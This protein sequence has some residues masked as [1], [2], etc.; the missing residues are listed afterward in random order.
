MS[1]FVEVV[2]GAIVE[3][4]HPVSA[5]VMD[6]GGS[7]RAFVGDPELQTFFR[8]SAK[9][10]QA[11]P[12]VEDGAMDRFDLSLEELALCCGSHS[13]APVH[14]RAAES[15][16]AKIG[17]DAEA[18][19]CG[20]HEPFDRQTRLDLSEAGLEPGRLHNNC[21]GKH[22]GMMAVARAHGWDP[23]GYDRPEH[24]VQGR[25]LTEITRWTGLPYESIGLATDGCGVVC[26]GLPLTAMATAFARFAAA[27]RWGDHG[28]ATVVEA[29][30]RHPE[31]VAGEGRLCTALMRQ[32]EGRL[33]AKLGA[34]GIY[35]VGV[36]GAELGIALKVEDGSRRA[37]GPALMAVLQQLDLLPAEDAG[38]LEAFAFPVLRNTRGEEVGHIVSRIELRVPAVAEVADAPLS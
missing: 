3:S 16:L 34:E 37:V 5:V 38:A 1:N 18:L 8:S 11:L 21:S 26:Y 4:R 22:A 35:C 17:L 24:P 27:A 7:M 9:P 14:V 32:T 23:E 36:P 6:A 10:L 20:P 30:T 29:M 28:P 15:I 25:L 19:V 12:L 13:G 31:M 33:F 2:R